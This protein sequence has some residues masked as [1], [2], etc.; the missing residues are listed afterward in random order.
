MLFW[1]YKNKGKDSEV[2]GE[3]SG[4][5]KDDETTMDNIR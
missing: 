3:R 4:K 1:G 5:E 2:Q